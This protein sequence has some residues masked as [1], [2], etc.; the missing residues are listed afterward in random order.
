MNLMLSNKGKMKFILIVSMFCSVLWSESFS[1]YKIIKKDTP[2]DKIIEII[3]EAPKGMVIA[4]AEGEYNFQGRQIILKSKNYLSIESIA[5]G[6]VIFSNVLIGIL[7]SHFVQIRNIK[8]ID[9][10]GIEFYR[11]EHVSINQ[12]ELETSYISFLDKSSGIIEN[13][14]SETGSPYATIALKGSSKVNMSDVKITNNSE[15]SCAHSA[16][17]FLK[18]NNSKFSN[19]KSDAIVIK[20]SKLFVSNSEFSNRRYPSKY[21]RKNLQRFIVAYDK[22]ELIVDNNK[23]RNNAF[24]IVVTGAST[25]II[26]NN[27]FDRLNTAIGVY[28]DSSGEIRKNTIQDGMYN[29]SGI[30]IL[31]SKASIISNKIK[32][33]YV[34]IALKNDSTTMID[35]NELTNLSRFNKTKGVGIIVRD[36]AKSNITNTKYNSEFP[37]CGS[38]SKKSVVYLKGNDNGFSLPGLWNSQKTNM[39]LTM[40]IEK[41]VD[42]LNE[43]KEIEIIDIN[44]KKLTNIDDKKYIELVK[45]SFLKTTNGFLE[46]DIIITTKEGY[47]DEI[48]KGTYVVV[49]ENKVIIE[50]KHYAGLQLGNIPKMSVSS[51]N[52]QITLNPHMVKKNGVHLIQLNIESNVKIEEILFKSKSMRFESV[53]AQTY[54]T[55]PRRIKEKYIG[56]T[57]PLHI[58]GKDFTEVYNCKVNSFTDVVCSKKKK[59]EVK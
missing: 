26:N 57:Y 20:N 46:E 19:N 23:F 21:E 56:K 42:F 44:Y 4:F 25:F 39:A 59:L 49:D 6:G 28:R 13:L 37:F 29:S 48:E 53:N 7:D 11:T 36:N 18:I 14:L 2:I 22:S 47:E 8:F 50:P 12:V 52:R 45:K 16:G 24:G 3:T 32:R 1:T 31:E 38:A 15:S 30:Q 55:I 43:F 40:E 41:S 10:S 33:V 9:E 5:N 54:Q 27:K 51:K 34:G 17:S 35:S 58:E